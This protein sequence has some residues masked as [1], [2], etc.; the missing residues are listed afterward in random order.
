MMAAAY[1]TITDLLPDTLQEQ[2]KRP[3]LSKLQPRLQYSLP[4]NVL[5]L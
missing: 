5:P 4:P 3:R 2:H 1:A